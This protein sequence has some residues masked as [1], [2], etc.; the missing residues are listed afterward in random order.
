[1][2]KCYSLPINLSEIESITPENSIVDM[3]SL[4]FPCSADKQK[5][6]AF[7]FIRNTNLK[8]TYMFT[9]CSYAGKCEYMMMYYTGNIAVHIPELDLE[10]IYILFRRAYGS[11]PCSIFTNEEADR[12]IE[13][14][15]DFIDQVLQLIISL[16]L[17]SIQYFLTDTENVKTDISLDSFPKS[18]WDKLNMNN[19]IHL[20]DLEP[21]T[22]LINPIDGLK[23]TYYTKYFFT[24]CNPYMQK[25]LTGLPFLGLLNAMMYNSG[26]TSFADQLGKML[27]KEVSGNNE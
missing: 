11:Q 23:P 5:R 7:L 10:W 27:D 4:S 12:F 18:D 17:C 21:I 6:S 9:P 13:E 24:D 2:T 20:L 19:F 3:S 16:P 26:D 25:M 15:K 1:M 8:T 22:R 14:H